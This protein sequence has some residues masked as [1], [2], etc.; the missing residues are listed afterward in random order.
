MITSDQRYNDIKVY[1]LEE[2][3]IF[4]KAYIE[5]LKK[6]PFKTIFIHPEDC[7]VDVPAG[8]EWA[9]AAQK[10]G[11]LDKYKN[12]KLFL[13]KDILSHGT[14]S[15]L[16]V[17]QL[18]DKY[19]VLEGIHRIEAIQIYATEH[20]WDYKMMALAVPD[21]FYDHSVIGKRL[22]LEVY[23]PIFNVEDNFC[24]YTYNVYHLYD[25]YNRDVYYST[26]K[27]M[28]VIFKVHNEREYIRV[29]FIWHKFLRHVFFKYE[30]ANNQ[31]IP[32]SRYINAE[33][34]DLTFFD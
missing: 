24:H 22:N 2:I 9:N 23:V 21:Y 10:D 32:V 20:V 14:H 1:T 8:R 27:D 30:Q 31:R 3:V 12:D 18:N 15:P 16:A 25:S 17:L 19:K 33:R 28:P 11:Y 29:L 6:C 34:D 5:T 26:K 7:I 4:Y 13:A